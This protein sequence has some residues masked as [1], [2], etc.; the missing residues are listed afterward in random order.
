MTNLQ[1]DCCQRFLF[2][3]GN[4]RGQ[5]VRLNNSLLGA[6]NTKCYSDSLQKLLGESL[7]AA[8]LLADTIKLDGSLIMQVQGDGPV[9]TLVAQANDRGELRGMAHGRDK[10]VGDGDFRSLVG[11]GRMV[12]TIDATG[13]ERYQ[14]VVALEGDSLDAALEAYFAQSEQLP[15]R[16]WLASDG[17]QAGGLLL[18]QL[19][20]ELEDPEQWN[21]LV[22]LSSTITQAELMQLSPMELIN[23]LYH[24]ESLSVY[25]STPLTFHC[26]CSREKIESVL[27][28]LGRKEVE[29][30]ARE[31][32]VVN[33]QCE[34]CNQ[35]FEFDAVDV[36]ALFRAT[37]SGP[38]TAQ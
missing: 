17:A 6:L 28:Q 11:N 27:I 1:F 13:N 23:R 33:V 22:T 26:G 9:S 25:E 36:S 30:I 35:R 32:G 7:T 18:Q 2:E 5:I 34:F 24:Q 3:H 8:A 21:H 4:V 10:Q 38:S 37:V 29:E 31:N 12:I 16:L 19:P 14:G 20:G 15:T